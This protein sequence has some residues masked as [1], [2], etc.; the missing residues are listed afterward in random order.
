MEALH[1]LLSKWEANIRSKRYASREKWQRATISLCLDQ[2][3]HD[4]PRATWRRWAECR[5]T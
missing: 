5:I 3:N 2:K 4:T 1:E